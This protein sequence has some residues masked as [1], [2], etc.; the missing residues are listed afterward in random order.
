MIPHVVAAE[1]VNDYRIRLTFSDGAK[2]IVDFRAQ[3]VGRGGVF[4]ALEVPSMFGAFQI[5]ADA[6]TL[7]WP[8]GVDFCPATLHALAT[9]RGSVAA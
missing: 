3:I 2:G 9:G 5:D 6:G 7:V 4:A 1:I 8:N